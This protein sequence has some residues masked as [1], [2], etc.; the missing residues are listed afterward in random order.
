MGL[1]LTLPG[2]DAPSFRFLGST[3]SRI[4]CAA[5][6]VFLFAFAIRISNL[7]V[8]FANGVPQ[9]PPFDEIYHA[10]RIAYSAARPFRVLDF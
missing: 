3:A 10:K 8:A 9:F 2:T 6:G 5:L 4:A 1:R 7:P